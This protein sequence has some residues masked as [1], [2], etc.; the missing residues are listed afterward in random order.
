MPESPSVS[1]H[2]LPRLVPEHALRGGTAIVLDVLRA[3]TAMVYA[4]AA[5]CEAVVP[6]LEVDEARRVAAQL[7]RGT[8]LLGGERQGLPI[9]GFDL[10]NSPGSYTPEV[11]RGKT[12]VMTTTNGTRAVLAS[13]EADRVLVAAFANLA[14]TLATLRIE[15]RPI[16]V[17]CAGTDGLVS[18]E[19]TLLAGAIVAGLSAKSS[20]TDDGGLIALAAWRRAEARIAGDSPGL[21]DLLAE[22]RGGR[23]VREIGLAPDV[24]DA[25]RV[26]RFPFTAELRRDPLRIVAAD[27]RADRRVFSDG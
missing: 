14:A 13:L 27:S 4:L 17:V 9:E 26:D 10:G 15:T 16:H 11:C 21:A 25:S 12:L 20:A 1:V 3:T 8:A 24:L 19:D 22:G 18:L 6:C 23:R 5:G 2:L 7:H